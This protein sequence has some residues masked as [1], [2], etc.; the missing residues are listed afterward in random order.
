MLRKRRFVSN[1]TTTGCSKTAC[2][3]AREPVNWV[4]ML[5]LEIGTELG[6]PQCY[7]PLLLDHFPHADMVLLG[8]EDREDSGV[9]KIYL[10]FWD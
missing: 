1:S 7:Q 9:F 4:T 10:E 6:M 3:W 2:R 8:L 5:L